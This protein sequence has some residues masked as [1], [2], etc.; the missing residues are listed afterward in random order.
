MLRRSPGP[1]RPVR[2]CLSG[3]C[4]VRARTVISSRP[5]GHNNIHLYFIRLATNCSTDIFI[6]AECHLARC[7]REQCKN[8]TRLAPPFPD[9]KMLAAA[10]H[11]LHFLLHSMLTTFLCNFHR[12]VIARSL[13][14]WRHRR[15]Q[16]AR[17]GVR[18]GR[19]V[20]SRRSHFRTIENGGFTGES[21]FG[22][23]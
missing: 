11:R 14:H 13:T 10:L 23:A 6:I 5:K 21:L 18:A 12:F 3:R 20:G 19:G 17:L 1:A 7:K 4:V 2:V 16:P 8:A 15:E 9:C 22:H